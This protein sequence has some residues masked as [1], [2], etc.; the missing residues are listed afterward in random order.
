M[1][2]DHTI[3]ASNVQIM[4]D[5]VRIDDTRTRFDVQIHADKADVTGPT[6]SRIYD[7]LDLKS[8]Y[9]IYDKITDKMTIHVQY[10]VALSLLLQ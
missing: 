2:L 9:G 8:V 5:Q 1:L 4:L 7:N 3:N 6:L 10:S